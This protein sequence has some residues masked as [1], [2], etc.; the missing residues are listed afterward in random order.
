MHSFLLECKLSENRI[1]PILESF[2]CPCSLGKLIT[3]KEDLV[4]HDATAKLFKT[5][6]NSLI[7]QLL[8]GVQF[9]HHNLVAHL[10]IKPDNIVIRANNQLRIIDF[11]VSDQVPLL[12]LQIKGYQG[13]KGWVVPE[14][15]GNPDAGYQPI[16]AD[17]WSTGRV[18]RHL[19]K[20]LPAHHSEIE[21]LMDRLQDPEP[22]Q[23]PL[24]SMI[25]LDTLFRQP[26]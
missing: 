13:T 2:T 25:N 19:A 14:V 22:Q 1:V 6:G 24:L 11:S 12:E 17:L 20:H 7:C 3:M 23:C 16:H 5:T 8:E 15:K 9:I 21:S 10:D 26:F 18:I 4:L